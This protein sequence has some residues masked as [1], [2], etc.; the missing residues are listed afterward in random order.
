MTPVS[1]IISI[2]G[3]PDPFRGGGPRDGLDVNTMRTL[4]IAA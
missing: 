2:F 3:D 1:A 4:P